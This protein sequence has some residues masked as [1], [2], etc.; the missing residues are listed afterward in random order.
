[1]KLT[2]SAARTFRTSPSAPR[3][4]AVRPV[5][6]ASLALIATLMCTGLPAHA[7]AQANPIGEVEQLRNTTLALIQALVDQGLISRE[8]AN[9]LIRGVAQ[10]TV[11]AGPPAAAAAPP[12]GAASAA[13][14]GRPPTTVR[15]PYLPEGLKAQIKE[16]IK[17]DV[18]VTAREEGWA[19]SR[20]IPGWLRGITVEGDVRVRAQ[21]ELFD[22]GNVP[23]QVYRTQVDSPAWSPDLTNTQT[24]RQRLTLRAR[25]GLSGKMSDDVSGGIRLSTGGATGP[26]SSSQTLG[27]NFNKLSVVMDRAWLRWEPRYNLRIE[28]GRM[29]NPFF[30]SDLIWPDDLSLDGVALRAEQD[31]GTGVLAYATGGVFPL[32]E[33]AVS[34]GDKWLYGVQLGT[35]LALGTYTQM[36]LGVAYYN[37]KNIEG[38]RETS[39]PPTG[40]LAGTVPYQ[41]SQY[42]ASARQKGNTLI[43]LNDPSSTA[44]PVWGLAS[45]FT[46]I[47][48]TAAMT[49]SHFNPLQIGVTFDYVKNS[50][51]DLTDIGRRAGTS[52]LS[53]LANKT[54]GLQL[55]TQFGTARLAERGDW[56]AFV[57]MRKFERDAW[58]DAFTDTTWHLG[59]TN[60]KGYSLG[61]AYTLDRNTNFGLRWTST[62]NL[63]D[64]QRFL[65]V[66]GDPT[67]VSGN[68]SSAPL[69]IDVI[70]IEVTSKF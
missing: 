39:P 49:F 40:S 65:A 50:G 42:P 15:V 4:L 55:R 44:A 3:R 19:D 10:G 1:M 69:K 23:A 34:R 9:A 33:F 7:Q 41:A 35:D 24:A 59:G 58:V 52:A 2:T 25:L 17:N 18:L 60:Y 37:F 22:E 14:W 5:T 67:S 12:A 20:R 43:N 48:L 30:G 16:D 38:E 63:D 56:N 28:G 8:R 46:P 47:N 21:G 61:G 32:E 26:A 70:Q 31:L 64:G 57:A 62:R 53:D 11:A 68:L 27:S 29:P 54:T 45:K 13:E 36:R 6:A 66:P 51:F